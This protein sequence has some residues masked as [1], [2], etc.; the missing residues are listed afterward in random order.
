VSSPDKVESDDDSFEQQLA[1]VVSRQPQRMFVSLFLSLVLVAGMASRT[2]SLRW[3]FVWLGF[4]TAI[5]VLRIFAQARAQLSSLS[6]HAR[7]N[8][9][10]CLVFLSGVA[11]GLSLLFFQGMSAFEQAVLSMMLVGLA[12]G[13]V[14]TGA[15]YRP[16]FLAYIIPTLGP[17]AACWLINPPL[18]DVGWVPGLMAMLIVLFALVLNGLARDTYRVLRESYAIRLERTS[19]NRELRAALDVAETANRAKTRFLASASHDLRQPMQTLSLF[20]AALAMRPLDERSKSI[21]SHMNEALH[22]LTA[23]LDA[24][25]DISKLDAGTVKPQPEVFALQRVL[26]RVLTVFRSAAADKSLQM[27]LECPPDAWVCTDRRLLERVVRNLTENAIKYTE[28]GHVTVDVTRSS[29]SWVLGVSDTGCG[30]EASER[31]R[32][33]EEFYQIQNPERDRRRGLGLGLAIVKR[34]VDLLRL[35]L[36]LTSVPGEGTRFDVSVPACVPPVV[37]LPITREEPTST[38]RAIRV[39]LIDDE[40]SLRRAMRTML[41]EAGSVVELAAGTDEAA[42]ILTRKPVDLVIADFRL[43]GDDNGLHAVQVL[44]TIRPNL[45]ALLMTGETAPDRL[46]EAHQTG[47]PVLHKPVMPEQLLKEI[48]RITSTTT[49]NDSD[50]E[51]Q[52][53]V[54]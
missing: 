7:L 14:A 21:V 54:R 37:E 25:L 5:M 53:N 35:Q 42:E 17:L 22:D 3:I 28:S 46:R 52:G 36:S 15:G 39:L 13:S 20:A 26:E 48:S 16:I 49:G 47:I 9:I 12:A 10:V 8:L 2:A 23:E 43:C 18:R 31:E 32:I 27:E 50:D 24:L 41:E 38:R 44:R 40:E 30:I 6:P 19:L 29:G 45:P 4:A 11:H 1:T 33:F 34:L 51:R